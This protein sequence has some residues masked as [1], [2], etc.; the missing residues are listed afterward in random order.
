MIFAWNSSPVMKAKET[1]EKQE[2][3]RTVKEN[4]LVSM[5]ERERERERETL[6]AQ[7][8]TKDYIRPENKFQSL[9]Q[10]HVYVQRSTA[11][12]VFRQT[13]N[14]Q[15]YRLNFEIILRMRDLPVQVPVLHLVHLQAQHYQIPDFKHTHQGSFKFKGGGREGEVCVEVSE[16]S[17]Y[18]DNVLP[19]DIALADKGF[20]KQLE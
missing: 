16:E 14:V 8:T 12:K 4:K 6:S 11:S 5:R 18:L 7:P 3:V 2:R 1:Y 10:L 19:I 17:G 9:S 13:I 15:C 20:D